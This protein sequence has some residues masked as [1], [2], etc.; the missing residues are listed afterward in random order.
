M[1]SKITYNMK[2]PRE[3][4]SIISQV[5]CQLKKGSYKNDD[6]KKVMENYIKR[7]EKELP[8]LEVK[9]NEKIERERKEERNDDEDSNIG[10]GN[11]KYSRVRRKR[12]RE[13][14]T[15]SGRLF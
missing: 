4:R 14:N 5:K 6:D 9:W 3:V 1:K 11:P 10:F 2:N 7:L 8:K 12:R 13:D 15:K